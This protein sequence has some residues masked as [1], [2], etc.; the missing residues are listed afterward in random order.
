L[1][2]QDANDIKALRNDQTRLDS[3]RVLYGRQKVTLDT[4]IVSQRRKREELAGVEAEARRLLRAARSSRRVLEE[5]AAELERQR[6]ASRQRISDYLSSQ[7]PAPPKEPS[8][9]GEGTPPP[10][11]TGFINLRG[12]LPWPVEGRILARFGRK[13]DLATKTYTRNRGIDISVPKGTEVLSV[14][15]GQVVMV[16]WYRG[17]GSFLI[18][19]HGQNYYTLYAHLAE[20]HVQRNER[21]HQG[22]ILGLS[23]DSGTLGEA[24]LHFELLGGHQA[25]NPLEWL[26]PHRSG[27]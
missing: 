5:S 23:G 19:S 7:A 1:A 12:R 8:V 13:Q 4:M 10:E 26:L 16:D 27:T 21:I 2:R 11:Q 22:Q 25:L 6:Q 20:I 15:G 17:Y 24:K 3:L 18:I 9:F 14:G